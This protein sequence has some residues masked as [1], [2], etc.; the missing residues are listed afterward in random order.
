[1][2]RAQLIDAYDGRSN[3]T[4][5]TLENSYTPVQNRIHLDNGKRID[6]VLYRAGKNN[7]VPSQSHATFLT[8]CLTYLTSLQI[9]VTKFELPFAKRIPNGRISYS[10]HE[11]VTA[12]ICASKVSSANDKV[13]DNSSFSEAIS[14][15]KTNDH[16]RSTLRQS[17]QVC[18]DSLKQLLNNR[19]FYIAVAV[20]ALVLLFTIMDWEAPYGMKWAFVW[21]RIIVAAYILFNVVMATVWNAIEKNGILSGKLSMEMQLN[22]ITDV[23]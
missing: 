16:L 22:S 10:D 11:A 14:K 13:T 2:A 18:N 1:M 15:S 5:D 12:T 9:N 6:Y 7:E 8:L 17:I 3:G 20:S 21:F 19:L 23:D 4:Y